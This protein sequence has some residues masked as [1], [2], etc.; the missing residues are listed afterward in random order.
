MDKVK[1]EWSYEATVLEENKAVFRQ[2]QEDHNFLCMKKDNILQLFQ[3]ITRCDYARK[4]LLN[5]VEASD[6]EYAK[7]KK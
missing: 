7:K 3:V 4:S 6:I 2:M 1:P 5:L